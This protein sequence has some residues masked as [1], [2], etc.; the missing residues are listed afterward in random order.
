M[1]T[2]NKPG[3]NETAEDSNAQAS[4]AD[5]QVSSTG[6]SSDIVSVSQS[7][8]EADQLDA[9]KATASASHSNESDNSSGNTLNGEIRRRPQMTVKLPDGEQVTVPGRQP[10]VSLLLDSRPPQLPPTERHA[11]QTGVTGASD[12]ESHSLPQTE[13]TAFGLATLPRSASH[14]SDNCAVIHSWLTAHRCAS[15]LPRL[16]AHHCCAL[17]TDST[18]TASRLTLS[19]TL[20]CSLSR[21]L[22][23]VSHQ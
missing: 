14:V 20:F 1:E 4:L 18:C 15:L 3:V 21:S 22:L 23:S 17:L 12:A 16:R 8:A 13:P 2:L 11:P 10:S 19:F 5:Q 6:P 7:V 9:P